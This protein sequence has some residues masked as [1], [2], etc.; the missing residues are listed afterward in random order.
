MNDE[1]IVR[2]EKRYIVWV[3]YPVVILSDT[4]MPTKWGGRQRPHFKI[5][6]WVRLGGEGGEVEALPPPPPTPAA[7]SSVQSAPPVVEEPSLREELD[8]DIPDFGNEN[9]ES[10]K[11]AAAPLP[12]PRRNLKKPAKTSAKKPPSGRRTSSTPAE[13][14]DDQTKEAGGLTHPLL[15]CPPRR[16]QPMTDDFS[17]TRRCNICNKKEDDIIQIDMN[18]GNLYFCKE[19]WPDHRDNYENS[20][21]WVREGNH[22]VNRWDWED[23]HGIKPKPIRY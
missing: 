13:R 10:P 23:S 2:V 4:F 17:G 19:C 14:N 5:V 16:R 21:T 11:P 9:V 12:T 15:F 20:S 18:S 1:Q 22:F 3:P 6:R 7:P 8:D